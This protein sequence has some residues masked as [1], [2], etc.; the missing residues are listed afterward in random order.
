MITAT[1]AGL[2]KDVTHHIDVNGVTASISPGQTTGS[3]SRWELKEHDIVM[4][5]W[6]L[7]DMWTCDRMV[8]RH[9]RHGYML[10]HASMPW[11]DFNDINFPYDICYV[12]V[13]RVL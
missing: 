6:P 3:C 13:S 7:V 12:F 1:T 2:R 10:T 4:V 5:M 9:S 8:T 11:I